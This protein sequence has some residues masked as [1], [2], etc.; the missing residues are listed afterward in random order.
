MSVLQQLKAR[1][2]SQSQH[3]TFNFFPGFNCKN[4]YLNIEKYTDGCE[5]GEGLCENMAK[6][7]YVSVHKRR[8]F[9]RA[10]VLLAAKRMVM[11]LTT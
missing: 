2:P 6:F 5:P 1:W 10:L 3:E 11:A 7:H 8:E 9:K 4:A